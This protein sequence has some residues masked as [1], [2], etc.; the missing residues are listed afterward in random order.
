MGLIAT[1]AAA[2]AYKGF[3]LVNKIKD[4]T[5][6]LRLLNKDYIEYSP[7]VVVMK[8]PILLII[9]YNVLIHMNFSKFY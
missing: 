3:R 2:V 1:S 4:K 7:K 6:L 5:H 8:H 9:I